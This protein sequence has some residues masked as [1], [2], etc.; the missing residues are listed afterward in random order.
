MLLVPL[1]GYIAGAQAVA[2]VAAVATSLREGRIL[3]FF[4]DI[5]W[6]VVALGSPRRRPRRRPRPPPPS[7]T[8]RRSGFRSSSVCS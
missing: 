5:E 7:P 4:R 3:V 8:P 2:P 6:R 1:I